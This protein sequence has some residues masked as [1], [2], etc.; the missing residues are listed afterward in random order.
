VVC[1]SENVPIEPDCYRSD[2]YRYSRFE[3]TSV[4]C[5]TYIYLWTLIT[6]A[7]TSKLLLLWNIHVYVKEP[8]LH[9]YV[10]VNEPL[11][12]SNW[13]TR[14]H[15]RT[16]A[17]TH[18]HTHKHAHTGRGWERRS[19]VV[20]CICVAHI[21]AVCRNI[22]EGKKKDRGPQT[23]ISRASDVYSVL[24]LDLCVRWALSSLNVC[25][26]RSHLRLHVC[27]YR[28]LLR[29][30]V[31]IVYVS[32]YARPKMEKLHSSWPRTVW[33][34]V[35]VFHKNG[36]RPLIMSNSTICYSILY[37]NSPE[38]Y[39]RLTY[40]YSVIS[41]KLDWLPGNSKKWTID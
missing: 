23:Y 21:V 29:M 11:V 12:H 15:V 9:I 3:M 4:I 28:A 1:C 30:Q 22:Q 20:V 7:P 34:V 35:N 8:Y 16:H 31:G 40:T 5:Y 24:C 27:V 10:Y 37:R 26:Y 38:L 19:A 25:V 39:V 36:L 32:T 41:L 33:C 13:S 14:T 2:C 6:H 18:V 17:R